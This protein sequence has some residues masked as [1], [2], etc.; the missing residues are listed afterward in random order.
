MTY[1]EAVSVCFPGILS[2]DEDPSLLLSLPVPSDAEWSRCLNEL[3]PQCGE[4]PNNAWH[5]LGQYQFDLHNFG[6]GTPLAKYVDQTRALVRERGIPSAFLIQHSKWLP[7]PSRLVQQMFY[8]NDPDAFIGRLSANG[9]LVTGQHARRCQ[10]VQWIIRQRWPLD[11]N[12]LPAAA[13]ALKKIRIELRVETARWFLSHDPNAGQPRTSNL[14]EL[15]IGLFKWNGPISPEW[16]AKL[17]ESSP[18]RSL[19]MRDLYL[20][21]AWSSLE[22]ARKALSRADNSVEPILTA[23]QAL[24]AS[25]EALE[26]AGCPIYGEPATTCDRGENGGQAVRF[27]FPPELSM[28]SEA[29]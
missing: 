11:P 13:V 6:L 18:L 19:A 21:E 15:F 3:D 27:K 22:I 16:L 24:N 25:E 17:G 23:G 1:Q 2:M 9:K 7:W 26:L 20:V 10:M 4:D 14:Q 8:D 12:F 28:T 29:L 5:S